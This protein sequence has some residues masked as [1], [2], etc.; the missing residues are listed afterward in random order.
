MID[1]KQANELHPGKQIYA[2]AWWYMDK[3]A[4]LC[5][6]MS[7]YDAKHDGNVTHVTVKPLEGNTHTRFF[8]IGQIIS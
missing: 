7:T 3:R 2:K 5:E 6:I 1:Q 8:D 4:I